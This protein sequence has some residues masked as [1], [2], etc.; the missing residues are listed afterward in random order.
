MKGPEWNPLLFAHPST[1]NNEESKG[2][3]DPT[4]GV[5]D[6]ATPYVP[7]SKGFGFG[8]SLPVQWYPKPKT[9]WYGS[10]HH[11]HLRLGP[12]NP[13]TFCYFRSSNGQIAMNSIQGL[14]LNQLYV[15]NLCLGEVYSQKWFLCTCV[16]FA[17]Y[18]WSL[19]YQLHSSSPI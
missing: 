11:R 17:S 18:S 5:F 4:M 7:I 12:H 10:S 15:Y 2:C 19:N 16:T 8:L 14:V 6:G 9:F 13:W 1:F 3:M